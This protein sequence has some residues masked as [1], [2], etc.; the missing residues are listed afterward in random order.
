MSFSLRL[1][2]A[3]LVTALVVS[4]CPA[5]IALGDP[6]NAPGKITSIASPN[7]NATP[8][9]STE[10]YDASG[11][12]LTS[13]G[14]TF[15]YDFQ[16]RLIA[17]YSASVVVT[18]QYDADGNRISKT[19]NGVTTRYVVEAVNPTGFP[20]VAEELVN[21]VA[22]RTYSYGAQRI[23]QNQLINGAWV[24]SFYNYDASGSVRQ[25]TDPTGTVTDTYD[26]DAYGSL[27]HS[28]GST[29]NVYLY[30]GE[31]YDP[32][33]GLY[34]LRARYY[35]PVT[36]RFLTRDPESGDPTEP[37]SRHPYLYAGS[38][39]VGNYD[40][41]GRLVKTWQPSEYQLLTNLFVGT[42]VVAL[43][44]ATGAML[45]NWQGFNNSL[46]S[47]SAAASGKPLATT[48]TTNSSNCYGNI[49]A[50]TAAGAKKLVPWAQPIPPT[51]AEGIGL[52]LALTTQLTGREAR[53]LARPLAQV[54]NWIGQTCPAAG[55]C[56]PQLSRRWNGLNGSNLDVEIWNCKA[57]I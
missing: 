51:S 6:R 27:I 37:I 41:T 7:P 38:N 34:Y 4:V 46:S 20:Q 43:P 16:N 21:G 17:M 8:A 26:Y 36:G 47:A 22:Q 39:P 44:L 57:F 48:T 10:T 28:T 29:P 13:G 24:Q 54:Q 15:V 14:K 40:P 3:L 32:D 56:G 5:Q 11:N 45:A 30:R 18:L 2:K 23:S 12:T 49:H 42:A 55:G 25:L 31:E 9:V 53:D 19:V 33:L 50:H 52:L 35:N 1:V